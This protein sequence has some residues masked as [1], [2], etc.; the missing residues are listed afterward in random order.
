MWLKSQL[1]LK[2]FDSSAQYWD[3]RYRRQ[4]DSGFGSYAHLA[5]FKA[6]IIN[7]FVQSNHVKSVIEFGC[8]DGNQLTYLLI[9]KYTGVDVSAHAIERCKHL[10]MGDQSKSFMTT[11]AFDGTLTADLTM[12]LDVIYHLVEDDVFESYMAQ[13][14]KA[15][16][17]FVIIYSSNEDKPKVMDHVR[18]RKF[19]TWIDTY[20]PDF[21]LIQFIPNKYPVGSPGKEIKSIAD[22]YIYERQI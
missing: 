13:L 5:E 1:G 16:E 9:P 3:E 10:F 20:R 19:S 18:S 22:F 17:R 8:G 6:K 11:D 7:E 4:G 15:S 21:K 14:F 2:K 12:S